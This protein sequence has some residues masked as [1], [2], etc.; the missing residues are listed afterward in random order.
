M[1]M[2]V[3]RL[4]LNNRRNL[5]ILKGTMARKVL[6]NKRNEAYRVE[7]D[8]PTKNGSRRMKVFGK[9]EIIVSGGTIVHN[10]RIYCLP[11]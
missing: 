8:Y 11:L 5:H 4:L 1:H 2:A 3:V 9:K 7:I 10:C 6:I